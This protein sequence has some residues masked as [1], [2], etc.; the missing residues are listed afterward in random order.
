MEH[1]AREV[2]VSLHITLRNV[3]FLLKEIRK[4]RRERSRDQISALERALWQPFP[5]SLR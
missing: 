3:G 1:E 4:T 5:L 2:E